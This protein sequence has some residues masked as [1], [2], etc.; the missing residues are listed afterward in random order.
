MS[1]ITQSISQLERMN[2]LSNP[3]ISFASGNVSILNDLDSLNQ[4]SLIDLRRNLLDLKDQRDMVFERSKILTKRSID[5]IKT[6]QE[7]ENRPI[8]RSQH[9]VE[10]DKSKLSEM[11][12]EQTRL[13]IKKMEIAKRQRDINDQLES[14][15]LY[16]GLDSRKVGTGNSSI[17]KKKNGLRSSAN[18]ILKSPTLLNEQ[19]L[20]VITP[21]DYNKQPWTGLDIFNDSKKRTQEFMDLMPKNA[22]PEKDTFVNLNHLGFDPFDTVPSHLKDVDT[23]KENT[24]KRVAPHFYKLENIEANQAPYYIASLPSFPFKTLLNKAMD[25][26]KYNRKRKARIKKLKKRI[27]TKPEDRDSDSESEDEQ[28]LPSDVMA[29]IYMLLTEKQKILQNEAN[30]SEDI[31]EKIRLLNALAIT[32]KQRRDLFD[33]IAELKKKESEDLEEELRLMNEL[34][35]REK[36]R[37]AKLEADRLKAEEERYTKERRERLRKIEQEARK[38]EEERIKKYEK[39]KR[40]KEDEMIKKLERLAK[41]K[42]AL[43]E[44]T[45]TQR[46][47]DKKDWDDIKNRLK[48]AQQ[49]FN[50]EKMEK[51][52][53]S[54]N[55]NIMKMAEIMGEDGIEELDKLIDEL[56]QGRSFNPD[57]GKNKNKTPYNEYEPVFKSGIGSEGKKGSKKGK[58]KSKRKEKKSSKDKKKDKKSKKSKEKSKKKSKSRSKK[59]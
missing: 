59:K 45:G 34:D 53:K 50:I 25:L 8:F 32:K 29:P 56:D 43:G 26:N 11:L 39:E 49:P 21:P 22:L 31:T 10:Q 46:E 33:F 16:Q 37:L 48:R 2:E 58:E 19:T 3:A 38:E 5:Y 28:P 20:N 36:E 47:V 17:F 30:L 55:K 54:K 35:R 12:L 52:A 9:E 18:A 44:G 57:K 1:T 23:L 24:K 27:K 15:K 14:R 4:S 7:N 13:D 42:R 51:I 40:K 6:A 41:L